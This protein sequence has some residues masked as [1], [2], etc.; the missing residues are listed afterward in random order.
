MKTKECCSLKRKG[1]LAVELLKLKRWCVNKIITSHC[2]R[3]CS[4]GIMA[5][6]SRECHADN[7]TTNMPAIMVVTY[8]SSLCDTG[9]LLYRE[10]ILLCLRFISSGSCLPFLS[11]R[12]GLAGSSWGGTLTFPLDPNCWTRLWLQILTLVLLMLGEG[13][14]KILRE[15]LTVQRRKPWQSFGRPNN[16]TRHKHGTGIG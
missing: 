14:V 16:G 7:A 11:P 13:Y 4:S 3:W 10:I 8:I 2:H 5:S 9:L 6:G 1:R 12:P 15:Q